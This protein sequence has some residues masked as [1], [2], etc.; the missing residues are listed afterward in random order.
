VNPKKTK[1]MLMLHYQQ[2]EQKQS[3]KIANRSFEDVA[4]LI[5]LRTTPTDQNCM[6]ED[7]QSR[8]KSANACF[9][10]VQSFVFPPAV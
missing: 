6:H 5:Y 10:S 7:I 3:I 1:Y 2:A 4:T 9:H 8:L